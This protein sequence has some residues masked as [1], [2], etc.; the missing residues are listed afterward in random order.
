MTHSEESPSRDVGSTGTCTQGKASADGPRQRS[1]GTHHGG[2]PKAI[3]REA[4]VHRRGAMGSPDRMKRLIAIVAL[5]LAVLAFFSVH[6]WKFTS[7][8]E[9]AMAVGLLAVIVLL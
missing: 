3:F 1:C 6:I 4:R 2:L 9:L 7:L 5:V 8:R